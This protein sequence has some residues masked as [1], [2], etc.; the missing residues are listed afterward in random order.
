LGR[1]EPVRA[2]GFEGLRGVNSP[3]N[4]VRVQDVV[5]TLVVKALLYVEILNYLGVFRE[6]GV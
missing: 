2:W 6:V 3:L 5:F 1:E 4:A